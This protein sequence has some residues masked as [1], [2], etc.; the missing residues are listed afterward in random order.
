[1]IINALPIVGLDW[2]IK[3]NNKVTALLT[4]SLLSATALPV[5]AASV[6]QDGVLFS[7]TQTGKLIHIMLINEAGDLSTSIFQAKSPMCSGGDFDEMIN[8]RYGTETKLSQV[9]CT[10]GNL[11]I[12][13][14]DDTRNVLTL[15]LMQGLNFTTYFK[16]KDKTFSEHVRIKDVDQFSPLAN[17]FLKAFS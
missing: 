1:M 6:F 14:L 11:M 3:M 10:G 9:V 5:N 2:R 8:V 16:Y 17:E 15:G 4:A 12:N 13:Q 7:E